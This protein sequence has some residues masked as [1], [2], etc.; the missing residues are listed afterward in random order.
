MRRHAYNEPD[1]SGRRCR[2]DQDAARV[3][4]NGA[5][6]AAGDRGRRVR[7][8]R[9]TTALEPMLREFLRAQ[10][11]EPKRIEAACF[12]VAGAVTGQVAR[13]TNVPWLV[14]A[15]SVEAAFRFRRVRVINDLEALAYGVTVLEPS[16]LK[17]L[18]VGDRAARRQCRRHRR[19]HRPRRSD[20]AQ[21]R[22]TFRAR[23]LR[24]RACRLLG[25]DTARARDGPGDDR[26]SSAASASNTSSPVSAW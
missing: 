22:W 18:Q 14:E 11:V 15:A 9:R 2:R 10:N 1:D 3:V 26:K 19:R 4:F 6:A 23:R 21:R 24:G 20:A 12:G 8:A 17:A 5:G 25:A 7:H 13:L 16:E